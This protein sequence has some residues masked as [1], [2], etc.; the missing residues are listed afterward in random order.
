LALISPSDVALYL[1]ATVNE[2][3]QAYLDALIPQIDAAV[4]VACNRTWGTT[5]PQT[6]TSDGGVTR[7]LPRST[8]IS[9]VS[10]LTVNGTVLE[11]DSDYY[12]VPGHIRFA[13]KVSSGFQNVVLK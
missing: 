8:P 6:E 2:S 1:N 4:E 3:G 5:P 9:S 10:A 7:L 11:Q 13:Y 12:V